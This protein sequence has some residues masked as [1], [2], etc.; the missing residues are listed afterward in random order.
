MI[1]KPE[2]SPLDEW[3]R[4]VGRRRFPTQVRPM[5]ALGYLTDGPVTDGLVAIEKL[6]TIL[7]YDEP[8]GRGRLALRLAG[9]SAHRVPWGVRFGG[10]GQCRFLKDLRLQPVPQAQGYRLDLAET[11]LL[12]LGLRLA[13]ELHRHARYRPHRVREQ[14]RLPKLWAGF[15]EQDAANLT[16]DGP[17]LADY[18]TR[19][20][21]RPQDLMRRLERRHVGLVLHPLAWVSHHWQEAVA[22]FA[23]LERFPTRQVFRLLHRPD[24]LEGYEAAAEYDFSAPQSTARRQHRRRS[25]S[26]AST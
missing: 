8:I 5:A 16:G 15:R 9:Y 7:L 11:H 2:F 26:L 24:D 3:R 17:E 14:I 12:S 13:R 22:V 10:P 4:A 19:T 18:A 25:A 1:R 21:K 20:G 6:T 23:D